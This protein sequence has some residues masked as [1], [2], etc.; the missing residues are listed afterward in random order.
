MLNQHQQEPTGR[1]FSYKA[2]QGFGFIYCDN[3][4]SIFFHK[5]DSHN[6]EA[7]SPGEA[8]SFTLATDIKGRPCAKNVRRI[9]SDVGAAGGAK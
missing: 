1:V 6:V 3:G 9:T 2:L 5:N 8:V 4:G 7:L